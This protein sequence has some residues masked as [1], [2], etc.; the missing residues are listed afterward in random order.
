MQTHAKIL[1]TTDNKETAL[2]MICLYAHNAKVK[3]WMEKVTVLVWGASQTLISKDTELQNKIKN[4]IEDGVVVL[5]CKH[6]AEELGVA[7][8]LMKCGIDTHSTGE[9]L[10]DWI[11]SGEPIVSV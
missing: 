9:L 4:M 3:N 10:S 8:S 7:T 6:C 5:A 2:N 11:K 1:W